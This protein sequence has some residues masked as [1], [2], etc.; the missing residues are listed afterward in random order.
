MKAEHFSFKG[1]L[2]AWE[3][4]AEDAVLGESGE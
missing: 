4:V 2:K 3:T 1:E